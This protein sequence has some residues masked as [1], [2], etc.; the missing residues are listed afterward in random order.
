[1]RLNTWKIVLVLILIAQVFVSLAQLQQANKNDVFFLYEGTW[2]WYLQPEDPATQIVLKVVDGDTIHVLYNGKE[3]IVRMIGLDTPETVHP[4]KPVQYFGPEASN[5][6]K[7]ILKPGEEILLT[8][9]QNK[10]DKYGRLLAYVWFKAKMF[11]REYWF[12]YNLVAIYNGY[13]HQYLVFKFRPDY[14]QIFAKAE[15]FQ[16]DHRLGMYGSK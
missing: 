16:K 7:S 2:T 3:E 5:F 15:E 1:M 12:L 10:K 6:C 4:K 11:N 9:D 13:G 8:F 14:V